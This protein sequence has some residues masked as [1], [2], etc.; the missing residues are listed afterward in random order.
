MAAAT[1]IAIFLIPMLYVLVERWNGAEKRRTGHD[2][3][4]AAL[5]V[6]SGS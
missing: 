1:V 2:T 4:S 3:G 5:P 6:G